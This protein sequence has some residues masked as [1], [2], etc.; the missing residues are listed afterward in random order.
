VVGK[1]WSGWRECGLHSDSTTGTASLSQ[2]EERLLSGYI[3]A[4][5]DPLIGTIEPSMY[6]SHWDWDTDITPS[7]LRPYAKEII[8]NIISVHSQV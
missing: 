3:E 5:S 1:V 7:D 8:A 6:F 4:K 2:L